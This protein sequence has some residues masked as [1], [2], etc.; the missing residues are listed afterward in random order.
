[1]LLQLFL[2]LLP[3]LPRYSVVTRRPPGEEKWR[4][5]KINNLQKA[6]NLSTPSV[7]S[8]S[9]CLPVCPNIIGPLH[10]K[11]NAPGEKRKMLYLKVRLDHRQHFSL[12]TSFRWGCEGF[13]R[14][15]VGHSCPVKKLSICSGI[16]Q[17]SFK[18]VDSSPLARLSPP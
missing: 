18:S 15:A 10:L 12:I 7:H 17:F 13:N 3:L 2:Y 11:P 9:P 16:F 1:M 14:A 8:S 4:E 5:E 6:L